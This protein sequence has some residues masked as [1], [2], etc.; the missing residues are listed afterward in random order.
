MW[1]EFANTAGEIIILFL[2]VGFVNTTFRLGRPGHQNANCYTLGVYISFIF[3][4]FC[5]QSNTVAI[6]M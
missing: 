1:V 4:G 6:F 2:F 5:L 3:S